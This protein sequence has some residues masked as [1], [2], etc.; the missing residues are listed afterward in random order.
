MRVSS[1]TPRM[2]PSRGFSVTTASLIA[3]TGRART[4][5]LAGLAANFCFSFV[6]GLIPSR[7]GRAGFFTTT[8]FAKPGR[9][10]VP[11]FFSSLWATLDERLDDLLLV[12][13]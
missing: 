9:T 1:T 7:A 13:A 11:L 3:F 5:L 12:L 4:A 2:L 6:K 8:N 10:N